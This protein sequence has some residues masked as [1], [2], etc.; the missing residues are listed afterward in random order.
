MNL[1]KI[2][3]T[4]QTHKKG[5]GEKQDKSLWLVVFTMCVFH[6]TTGRFLADFR[7]EG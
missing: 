7:A 3:V 1:L 2:P 4:M 5:E 6:S